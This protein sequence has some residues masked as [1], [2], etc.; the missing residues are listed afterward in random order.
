MGGHEGI[1]RQVLDLDG[2]ADRWLGRRSSRFRRQMRRLARQAYDAGIE[3][4][5]LTE[6][7][8]LLDRLVAI[9]RRGWKGREAN[10]ITSPEMRHFYS[11]MVARL[12]PRKRLRATIATQNGHDVAFILG[13]VRGSMYRGLQLSYV[14]SVRDLSLG[15]VLQLREIHALAQLGIA[16]YDLGMDMDYKKRFADRSVPSITLVLIRE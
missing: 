5:D 15:H 14:E 6:S 7:D 1:V 4:Q 11:E 10:G 16:T 3:F 8:G 13:G 9:E 2:D 12:G